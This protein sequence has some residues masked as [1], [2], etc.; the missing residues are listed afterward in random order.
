MKLFIFA[1]VGQR[2]N[3]SN[4]IHHSDYDL[5][6]GNHKD[7]RAIINAAL[8]IAGLNRLFTPWT[9]HLSHHHGLVRFQVSDRKLVKHTTEMIL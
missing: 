4:K 7:P 6:F 2:C 5:S 3:A 8:S 1:Q 9:S